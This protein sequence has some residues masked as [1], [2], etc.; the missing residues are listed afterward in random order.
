MKLGNKW[1]DYVK[2]SSRKVYLVIVLMLHSWQLFHFQQIS[3]F[4]ANLP[5]SGFKYQPNINFYTVKETLNY[6]KKDM[7][8]SHFFM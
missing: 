3:N 7:I 1:N 5:S 2:L 8:F 4:Y 6:L